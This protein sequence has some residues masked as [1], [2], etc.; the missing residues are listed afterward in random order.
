M[1]TITAILFLEWLIF[2]PVFSQ[3]EI[4]NEN[5]IFYRNEKTY[6]ITLNSNGLGIN[7]RYARRIDAFRKTIY[8]IE[9]N[10]IKH[11]I[12]ISFSNS[13]QLGGSF[14]Y[15]KLNAF[16]ALHG[17]IGFQKELFRKEDKGGISIRYFYAFGPSV[18]FLKP[19][20]YDVIVNEEND[21]GI[22]V[23]VPKR[24]KF[25]SHIIMIQRKAPFYVGFDELSVVPGAYG[26][27]GFTFEFGKSDVIFNAIET[28]IIL[29]A[30]IK[31]IPIMAND[32]N[33][34][35]FPAFFLSYR[36]GRVVNAQFK[37]KH[38]KVEEILTD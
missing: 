33:H 23:Q 31:K 14:V 20:Y 5:K 16:A 25:E 12:K 19:V 30:F 10:Q 9:L 27:L 11:E 17:G 15:G 35:I 2:L 36:F 21:Q 29:D 4:D 7:F 32:Q 18:G 34:W 6:A 3:G 24:M 13:Q 26:K 38:T 37:N 1:K 8:E 28:G 22:L